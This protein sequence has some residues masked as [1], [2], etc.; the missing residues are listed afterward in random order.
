[1]MPQCQFLDRFIFF[2]IGLYFLGR[3]YCGLTHGGRVAEEG[4]SI[5]ADTV[6][7]DPLCSY[8]SDSLRPSVHHVPTWK[9]PVAGM[10]A[11]LFIGWRTTRGLT[12]S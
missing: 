8:A 2:W 9:V 1:M 5:I 3:L 4:M 12:M 6:L 10:T 11:Y 7:V